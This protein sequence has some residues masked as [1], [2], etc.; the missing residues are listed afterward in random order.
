VYNCVSEW[1]SERV[2][3]KPH[4]VWVAVHTDGTILLSADMTVPWHYFSLCVWLPN[5]YKMY[6]HCC[7]FD[8][9]L[10]QKYG[11]FRQQFWWHWC[12]FDEKFTT[13]F[14]GRR[15]IRNCIKWVEP[16]R[17]EGRHPQVGS[18]ANFYVFLHKMFEFHKYRSRAWT[19]F[20]CIHNW[21]AD[22]RFNGGFEPP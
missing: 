1:V 18:S 14:C 7:V 4:K 22:W 17:L 6:E 10:T 11:L 8:A 5:I 16:G 9:F 21:K 12:C 19:V 13:L 2:D 20:L 3:K 15:Y